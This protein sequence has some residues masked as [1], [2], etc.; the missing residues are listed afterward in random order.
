MLFQKTEFP[1]SLPKNPRNLKSAQFLGFATLPLL[2][3]TLFGV[4]MSVVEGLFLMLLFGTSI[5]TLTLGLRAEQAYD[6][7]TIARKPKLPLKLGAAAL[8]GL[9]VG[10]TVFFRHGLTTEAA[11]VG[12]VASGLFVAA[13]GL[14]P[15]KN[16]GVTGPM[17]EE[18][19]RVNDTLENAATVLKEIEA[20]VATIGD[21]EVSIGFMGLRRSAERLFRVLREDPERHRDLRRLL[22]VYLDAARDATERFAILHGALADAEAKARYLGML[23]RLRDQFETRTR[24]YLNDGKSKLD[25]EIDVLQ[26]RLR[27]ESRRP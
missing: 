5:W 2:S 22:G 15:L 18:V 26:S 13:F 20:R 16:K 19:L 27:T 8:M 6:A 17:A 25:V 14:D 23:D 7:A 24:K 11:L 10:T 21:T 4:A 3:A 12:L 1:F 9:A